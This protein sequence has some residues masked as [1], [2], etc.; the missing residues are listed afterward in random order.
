MASNRLQQIENH[1]SNCPTQQGR[2]RDEMGGL[3]MLC[4]V[5]DAAGP[6]IMSE[7]DPSVAL[8]VY[9]IDRLNA[10]CRVRDGLVDQCLQALPQAMHIDLC[11]RCKM[12]DSRASS[13][14]GLTTHSPA[15]KS[16]TPL[17]CSPLSRSHLNHVV[18]DMHVPG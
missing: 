1:I 4:L 9:G 14:G 8:I 15:G 17:T 5:Q 18:M 10:R 12:D 13:G 3:L 2:D 6:T 16:R 7:A 11:C